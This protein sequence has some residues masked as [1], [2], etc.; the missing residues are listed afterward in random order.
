MY[1]DNNM[2]KEI[3]KL[4]ESRLYHG[5]REYNQDGGWGSAFEMKKAEC[6]C[7]DLFLELK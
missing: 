1:G 6:Y 2:N 4:I 7:Y 5:K 3:V